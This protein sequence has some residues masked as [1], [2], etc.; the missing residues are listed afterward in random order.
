MGPGQN[1]LTRVGRISRLWFGFGF[2]KFP[3]KISNLSISICPLGQKNLIGSGQKVP[4]SEPGRPL[5][6]CWS[7]VCSGRIGSHLYDLQFYKSPAIETY[8]K[9]RLLFPWLRVPSWYLKTGVEP[10]TLYLCELVISYYITLILL[11]DPFLSWNKISKLNKKIF[12]L[13]PNCQ[14]FILGPHL[15]IDYF[16]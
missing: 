11:I 4:V 12:F 3:Q 10:T 2:G 5:I 1:F 15:V 6:Y 9:C 13:L 14:P 16:G 7:K 8:G